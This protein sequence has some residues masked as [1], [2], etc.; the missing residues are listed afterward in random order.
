MLTPLADCT[1]QVAGDWF[2]VEVFS[3][4]EKAL[5][6]ELHDL[7]L[8]YY[9]P[10]VQRVKRVGVRGEKRTL[11]LPLFPNYIFAAGESAEQYIREEVEGVMNILQFP[12]QK[13]LRRELSSLEIALHAN[14]KL[15]ICDIDTVGQ[16]VRVSGGRFEGVE[17]YVEN[18]YDS[19][20]MVRVIV[21]VEMLGKGTPLDIDRSDLEPVG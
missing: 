15:E 11:I 6:W 17:G 10:L 20:G 21:R 18:F 12:S 4:H 2:A 19:R 3:R 5:A 1:A 9:L 13:Q 8:P 7:G 16:R 14:P